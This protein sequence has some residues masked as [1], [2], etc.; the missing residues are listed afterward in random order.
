MSKSRAQRWRPRKPAPPVT[1]IR[2]M[3]TSIRCDVDAGRVK[4]SASRYFAR[5]IP[6]DRVEFSRRCDVRISAD[7]VFVTERLFVLPQGEGSSCRG[8]AG[9]IR[10]SIL[11]GVSTAIIVWFFC[12]VFVLD[13]YQVLLVVF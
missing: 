8:E 6:M 11:N 5:N 3:T 13:V 10:S 9:V 1:K 4:K 12:G 7:D 2:F